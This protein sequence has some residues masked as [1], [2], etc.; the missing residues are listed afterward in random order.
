MT[1]RLLLIVQNPDRILEEKCIGHHDQLIRG[2]AHHGEPI[3]LIPYMRSAIA[4]SLTGGAVNIG[5]GAG[6]LL[7]RCSRLSGIAAST[8]LPSTLFKSVI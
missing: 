7:R 3:L 1:I 8:G 5:H 6:I 2:E 4:E